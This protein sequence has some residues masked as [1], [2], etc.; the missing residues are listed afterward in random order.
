MDRQEVTTLLKTIKLCYPYWYSKLKTE[1]MQALVALYET[2]FAK[3]DFETVHKA[4]TDLVDECKF[5]PTM[6]EIRSKIKSIQHSQQIHREIEE[7]KNRITYKPP[8]K[9]K[10][11]G[12]DY[13]KNIKQQIA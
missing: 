5:A 10:E 8:K 1:D 4:V 2:K 13:L 6:Q 9:L 3:D 7:S 12:L 11:I